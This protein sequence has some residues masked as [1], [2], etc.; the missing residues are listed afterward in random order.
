M[1]CASLT[2]NRG[3]LDTFSIAQFDLAFTKP[4][5]VK[6]VNCPLKPCCESTVHTL[7]VHVFHQTT[8]TVHSTPQASQHCAPC[9]ASFTVSYHV[10]LSS[11]SSKPICCQAR[12]ISFTACLLGRWSPT[13]TQRA[14]TPILAA[15]RLAP[16]RLDALQV[17]QT[18]AASTC[19]CAWA[20]LLASS[21]WLLLAVIPSM[22]SGNK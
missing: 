5:C 10:C 13:L 6:A 16:L 12:R 4:C 7:H 19:A 21:L 18:D 9:G 14:A 20:M 17:H 11:P 2:V 3:S 15:L 1:S 8:H 22:L